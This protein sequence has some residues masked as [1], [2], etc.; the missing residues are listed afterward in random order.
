MR[1]KGGEGEGRKK[2]VTNHAASNNATPLVQAL[3]RSLEVLTADVLVVDIDALGR[4]ALERIERLLLLV[5]EAAVEAEVLEDEVELLVGADGTNDLEALA[6]GDLADD[7]ADGA[8]SR[9]D[10]DGL[11]LLGAADL[12]VRRPGGQTGHAEGTEEETEVL[13]VVRVLNLVLDSL[14]D[15]LLGE[16]GI[17]GDGQVGDDEVALLVVG[18]G[19]LEDLGD[20]VVGDGL[21]EVVGGSVGL[22]VG[23]PHAA[24]LVGVERGIEDGEDEA[25]LG[26]IGGG[27]EAL[28]LDDEMLT[29]DGV[30]RGDLLEDEG[31]VGGAGHFDLVLGMICL[32]VCC[33]GGIKCKL[34]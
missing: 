11:A 22:G 34:W 16:G 23:L 25:A 14:A 8:G 6:L 9:A 19:G 15:L 33:R 30:V 24:T 27:V 13:E 1:A 29:R 26:G 32:G 2:G 17:L 5:V 20:G 28:V 3:E 10:K 21:V 4:E 7:L 12:V 18:V 31:L